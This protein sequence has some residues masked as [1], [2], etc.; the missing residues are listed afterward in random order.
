MTPRVVAVKQDASFK[1]MITVRDGVVT[2]TGRPENDRAGQELV[3]RGTAHRRR[4]RGPG[5]AELFGQVK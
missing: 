3:E 5:P 2:L 1:E 4:R